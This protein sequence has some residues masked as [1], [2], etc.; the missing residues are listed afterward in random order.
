MTLFVGGASALEYLSIHDAWRAQRAR[1]QMRAFCASVPC[2]AEVDDA[3]TCE[4]ARLSRP[5]HLLVRASGNRRALRETSTH[6]WSS[7]VPREAFVSASA[8]A[9]VFVCAPE[10]ALMSMAR[11]TDVLGLIIA[12]FEACGTFQTASFDARG[13]KTR[14]A[15]TTPADV[16][17][18]AAAAGTFPGAGRLRRA[19]RYAI[20]GAASP[21]EAILAM[22]LCLPC[23]LGG[24]G[25][26]R[27]ELNGRIDVPRKHAQSVDG[28]YYVCDLLW[29][30]AGVCVE[31]DSMMF[32]SGAQK[33]AADARRRDAL[34]LLGFEVHAVTAAQVSSA[35]LLDRVARLIA[36]RLGHRIRTDCVPDWEQRRRDLRRRLL[37]EAYG[38]GAFP[39][40]APADAACAP[41][42][43][44]AGSWRPEPDGCR[45]C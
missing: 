11:S 21:M 22:L 6:V 30:E 3:L 13:F 2:A 23:S 9:G 20:A 40:A 31:Y 5:V 43:G 42:L 24:Y 16:V 18:V 17:R 27:P 34:A 44:W 37:G 10:F 15:L 8:A 41:E 29:R 28:A 45:R 4:L 19:M 12:G 14:D 36:L 7:E 39:G 25:L 35:D 33:I 26:P 32:H 38:R 1:R